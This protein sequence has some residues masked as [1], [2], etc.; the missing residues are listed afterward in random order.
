MTPI[1]NHMPDRPAG[2][3]IPSPAV[4]VSRPKI[5]KA[6]TGLQASVKPS[7]P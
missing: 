2:N 1:I 5:G 7:A 6:V 4:R 3:W